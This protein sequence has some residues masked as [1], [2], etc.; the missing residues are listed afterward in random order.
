MLTP[1]PSALKCRCDS[2]PTH[3]TPEPLSWVP[4]APR[5]TLNSIAQP[6]GHL[7]APPLFSLPQQHSAWSSPTSFC[8]ECSSHSLHYTHPPPS[9]LSHAPQ[10]SLPYICCHGFLQ[11]SHL[12]QFQV[13]GGGHYST[14]ACAVTFDPYLS[15]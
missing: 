10:E 15:L 14:I 2:V 3:P 7:R 6:T 11:Y 4:T 1:L 13:P 12:F 5:M 8:L 9:P